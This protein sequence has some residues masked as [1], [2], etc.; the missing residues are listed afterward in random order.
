MLFRKNIWRGVY[1]NS[2]TIATHPYVYVFLYW[3]IDATGLQESSRLSYKCG[4]GSVELDLGFKPKLCPRT[5]MTALF[6]CIHELVI[7]TVWERS[8]P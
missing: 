4:Y 6:L 8:F 2:I 3:T 5:L 1:A 7:A